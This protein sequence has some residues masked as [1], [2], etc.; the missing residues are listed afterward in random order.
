MG[1]ST[2]VLTPGKTPI[3]TPAMN[4]ATPTPG[5]NSF[6]GNNCC[7]CFLVEIFKCFVCV[8]GFLCAINASF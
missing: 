7:F 8:Y 5:R 3:G 6:I 1:G 4:M 2:P